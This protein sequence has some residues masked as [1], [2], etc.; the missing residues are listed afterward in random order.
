MRKLRLFAVAMLTSSV[1][2]LGAAAP[3]AAAPAG[4]Q[5]GVFTGVTYGSGAELTPA[6]GQWS[7]TWRDDKV[8]ATFN[9]FVAGEHHLAYG[10]PPKLITTEA[11]GSSFSFL[12]GASSNPLVVTITDDQLTY[13][14]AP[15]DY[16]GVHY[17]VVTYSG[18]VS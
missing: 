6:S 17:D 12:T 4:T 16:N 18:T 2:L 11:A 7:V 13:R 5:H 9:I 3:A 1:A 15:Y 8:T 10:M 14:I